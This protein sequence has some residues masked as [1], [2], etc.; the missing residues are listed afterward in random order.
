MKNISRSEN[1]HLNRRIFS[2]A[3]NCYSNYSMHASIS[4]FPYQIAQRIKG[5]L[6]VTNCHQNSGRNL[7]YTRGRNPELYSRGLRKEKLALNY[8]GIYSLAERGIFIWLL[9]ALL[10]IFKR[11]LAAPRQR[12]KTSADAHK[13]LAL[14]K[15]SLPPLL[16]LPWTFYPSSPRVHAQD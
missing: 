14:N 3:R 7:Y 5:V 15:V 1:N 12:T 9:V 10:S 11:I 13:A 6:N 4:K 16:F 2:F 8:F